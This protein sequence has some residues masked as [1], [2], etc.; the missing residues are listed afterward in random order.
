VLSGSSSRELGMQATLS[1]GGSPFAAGSAASPRM[2]AVL[3]AAACVVPR[4]LAALLSHSNGIPMSQS[5][6]SSRLPKNC[7]VQKFWSQ[8]LVAA[9][10]S[11]PK[12]DHK[13]K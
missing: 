6:S 9:A 13:V 4:C 3:F 2:L 12:S 10:V 11:C 1:E 8:S 5:S 7:S